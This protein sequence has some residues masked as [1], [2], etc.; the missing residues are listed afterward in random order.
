MKAAYIEQVGPPEQI[1]YGELPD[2][3]IGPTEV[4][5]RVSAVAVDPVDTYIRSGKLPMRLPTPFIIGRDLGGRVE[6]VGRSVTRFARGDRVWSNNQGFDGRQGTFAEQLAIDQ[7]LLYRLPTGADEREVVAF[8]HSGLTALI[9]LERAQLAAGESIFVGGGAGNVGSAVIQFA[10]A[11]GA[12][13]FATAGS[14][15]GIDWCRGLGADGTANYKTDD[16]ARQA[17]LVAPGG[18]NVYCDTSGH[19]DFDQA[20]GLLAPGGRIVVMA[21]MAARPQFPV[22]PF[23]VKNCSL[24]GFAITYAR[25][26]QYDRAAVEINRHVEA[27]NL[28]VR[29]DRV[30]PLSAAAEAHRLVESGARLEGKLVLTP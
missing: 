6:R 10:R 19:N 16:V 30:L 23:Y 22:G 4:L 18:F 28:R 1:R 14:P 11:R 3:K 5:V 12:K 29:I 25:A 20:V 26:D 7:T 17:A 24:F 13:T 2:P 9:G 8:V 21:G 27:G 15:V